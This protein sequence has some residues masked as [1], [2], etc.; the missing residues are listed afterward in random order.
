MTA[1]KVINDDTQSSQCRVKSWREEESSESEEKEEEEELKKQS[2]RAWLVQE[3]TKKKRPESR[4]ATSFHCSVC[5]VG[6]S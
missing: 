3:G 1:R 6:V 2:R 4:A 5:P